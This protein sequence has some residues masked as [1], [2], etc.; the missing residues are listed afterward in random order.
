MTEDYL[1]VLQFTRV[2]RGLE[3]RTD[4]VERRAR[5]EDPRDASHFQGRN[6]VVGNDAPD[7]EENVLSTLALQQIHDSRHE[8]QVGARKKG[9]SEH[10]GVLLDDGLDDLLRRLV[11]TGVDDLESRVAQRSCDD[12]RAT[13]VSVET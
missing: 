7:D 11:Q 4:L 8:Y 2:Q 9:Q 1:T 13:I 5:G 6:V 10:V 12:L 3:P